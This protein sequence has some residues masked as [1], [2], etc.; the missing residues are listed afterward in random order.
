MEKLD[1]IAKYRTPKKDIK[2][3]SDAINIKCKSKM[4]NPNLHLSTPQALM[5]LQIH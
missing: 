2:D 5:N 1:K 3:L 4:K